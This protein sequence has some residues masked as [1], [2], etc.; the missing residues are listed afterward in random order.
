MK[1]DCHLIGEKIKRECARRGGERKCVR[2]G[3]SFIHAPD[4]VVKEEKG[5]KKTEGRHADRRGSGR[6]K[7]LRLAQR[8]TMSM[9]WLKDGSGFYLHA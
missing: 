3:D 8:L 7:C 4:S 6:N 2:H 1:R 5:A 9:G